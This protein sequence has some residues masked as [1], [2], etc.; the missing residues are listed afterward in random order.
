MDYNSF[1]RIYY[2]EI[3]DLGLQYNFTPSAIVVV[4]SESNEQEARYFEEKDS[5]FFGNKRLVL[6]APNDMFEKEM[7]LLHIR[8][9]EYNALFQNKVALQNSANYFVNEEEIKRMLKYVVAIYRK[10]DLIK[11]IGDK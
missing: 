11:P 1:I 2:N 8:F 7:D 6:G 10:M 4:N 3:M 9:P 5:G